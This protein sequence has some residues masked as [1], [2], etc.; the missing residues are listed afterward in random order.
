MDDTQYLIAFALA[1]GAFQGIKTVDQF[2][3][4]LIPLGEDNLPLIWEQDVE[5]L[6]I[7]RTIDNGSVTN[8]PLLARTFERDL[9]HNLARAGYRET[10]QVR[11][12]VHAIRRAL[13]AEVDSRHNFWESAYYRLIRQ[14]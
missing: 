10:S 1:D 13:A 7:V 14:L 8:R 9:Q 5:D 4:Q 2:F 6:P 3:N 12:T 11:V